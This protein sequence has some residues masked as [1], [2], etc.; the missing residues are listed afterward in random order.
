MKFFDC[1][2]K[3]KN[4]FNRNYFFAGTLLIILINVLV[5]AFVKK[6][7]AGDLNSDWDDTLNFSNITAAFISAFRHYDIGH[8]LANMICFVIVGVYLERKLGS[9]KLFLLTIGMALLTA[10]A[11]SVTDLS[12]YWLGFSVVN[13]GLYAFVIIDYFFSL[14]KTKFEKQNVIFGAIVI[15]FIYFFMTNVSFELDDIRFTWYPNDLFTNSGHYTGFYFGALLTL[16]IELFQVEYEWN[17]TDENGEKVLSKTTKILLVCFSSLIFLTSIIL[18]I[19]SVSYNNNKE[20]TV[21]VE[22]NQEEYNSEV[23]L[24]YKDLSDNYRI[25]RKTVYDAWFEKVGLDSDKVRFVSAVIKVKDAKTGVTYGQM[26]N[27]DD[28]SVSEL[29]YGTQ[30][31]NRIF[32]YV[33]EIEFIENT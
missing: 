15:A 7:P 28:L 14:R 4:W 18:P 6:N 24:K 32:C 16:L 22:C 31:G 11:T 26:S 33:V 13:Y 3:E 17:K 8:I 5:F 27:A 2:K 10:T 12:V 30:S 1:N 29:K 20:Y 9:I 23:V 25:S 21:Y 19:A